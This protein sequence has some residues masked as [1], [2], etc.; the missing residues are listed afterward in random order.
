[1]IHHFSQRD[2]SQLKLTL[3]LEGKQ[4]QGICE[5]NFLGATIEETLNWAPHTDRI[6]NKISRTLGVMN[7]LKQFLPT[8]TLRTT[9]NSLILNFSILSWGLHMSRLSKLQKRAVRIIT[10]N[11]YNAH[12]EPILKYLDLLKVN[13]MFT[14]QCLKFY[15][16]CRHGRAPIFFASFFH[17]HN[18]R[19]RHQPEILFSHTSRARKCI[20]F[21]IPLL[22]RSMPPC[23][24]DKI[25][26]HSL[27]GFS[28][29]TK[30]YM[31]AGYENICQTR[32]CYVCAH[33]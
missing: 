16:K 19:Q 4:I 31:L 18:T 11:K 14:L 27:N 6:A 2:V 21:H 22:L 7:K 15:F 3:N 30:Q 26:T 8:Y 9:Y 29:Y 13:D 5:F 17:D 32:N 33:A 12:T 24:I 25:Y 20:K 10:R 28:N 23:I 1:M